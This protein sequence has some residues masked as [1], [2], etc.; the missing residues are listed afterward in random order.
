MATAFYKGLDTYV[1]YAED[2]AFGTPGS[3][4]GGAYVDKVSSFTGNMTNNMIRVH[5][6]GEGRNASHI[7]NGMLDVTGSMDWELTD[8]AFMQYG[9]VGVKSG[10]GTVGSPYTITE[11][12]EIG[13][14]TG[15]I[16]TLTLEVGSEGGSNDDVMTYDGVVINSFTMTANQGETVKVSCDWIARSVT[17]STATEVYVKPANRPFT[18]IDG[19]ALVGT[20]VVGALMSMSFTCQNNMFVYRTMGNRVIAQPVCGVRRY[21]FTMTLKL[22]FNDAT[23]VLSGLEARGLVFNGTPTGT[24]PTNTAVNTGQTLTLKLIEG[25]TAGSRVV[26]FLFDGVYFESYSAP[27]EL[28]Q[29][30]IEITINGYALKG[31]AG[32]PLKWW[33]I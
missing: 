21:D 26:N 32:A 30:A 24:T 28:E 12:N 14:G 31:L 15:Q 4:T 18:F 19:S 13:Y 29:G 9:F 6:I 7:V 25:A 17:S 23:N 3:P 1:I 20:D 11:A 27:V 22:H 33:T 10:T 2:T 8:P 16:K 5:G